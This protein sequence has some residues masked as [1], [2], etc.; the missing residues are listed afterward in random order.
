VDD[1]ATTNED[2]AVVI[3]VV[4]NDTDVDG[5]SP[6]V[7]TFEGQPN[8]SAN[9]GTV[10][11]NGSGELVYT[12]NANFNGVDTITYTI[13]DNNGGTDEGQV[14][15]TVNAVNDDPV[16]VDDTATTNE[17][18]AVVID[19]I[20]NDTDADGNALQVD[21]LEG[22][23]V[24]SALNG[25]IAEDETGRLIYT[26][27]ANFNGNDTITYTI[28]DNNGGTDTGQVA[29]TVI[30]INDA[31]DVARNSTDAI[32]GE[33]DTPIGVSDVV[34]TDVDVG[35]A[36]MFIILT[37]TNGSATINTVAGGLSTATTNASGSVTVS[38]TL[39]Q[40]QTTLAD[41][42]GIT[43]VGDN[44]FIGQANLRIVVTDNG[45][46]GIGSFQD[47]LDIPI[48]IESSNSAPV[49]DLDFN[50]S[51]GATGA[52][53]QATFT[54][55]NGAVNIG[56]L[57]QSDITISDANDTNIESATITLTN[58]P[59]GVDEFLV[60]DVGAIVASSI[61]ISAYNSTSGVITLTGTATKAEYEQALENV[62][63]NNTSSNPTATD[64]IINV[65]I[66][67]GDADSNI[68]VS[69]ISVVGVNDAPFVSTDENIRPTFTEGGAAVVLNNTIM[70]SDVDGNPN[71][72]NPIVNANVL[73][74]QNYVEGEDILEF[75]DTALIES[76][77]Q[78]STGILIL[79]AKVGQTVSEA[80]FEAALQSVTYRNTSENPDG[81]IRE[82]QFRVSDDGFTSNSAVSE[83]AVTPVNDPPAIT[84]P[85]ANPNLV[86]NGG[87][88]N[89]PDGVG[90]VTQIGA[91]DSSTL[92]NWTVVSGAIDLVTEFSVIGAPEGDHV[93]DLN[94]NS[95]LGS[96]TQ[97]ISTVIGETYV[98][99]FQMSGDPLD[100]DTQKDVRVL[101]DGISTEFSHTQSGVRDP[102]TTTTHELFF[103]ATS[104]NTSLIFQSIDTD[105]LNSGAYI[106]DVQVRQANF[107]V[108][109]G[110]VLALTG[111]SVAD[112]DAST[113]LVTISASNGIFQAGSNADVSGFTDVTGHGTSTL[114]F[115]GSVADI[116][117]L[118]NGNLEFI[119][120]SGFDGVDSITLN[121]QDLGQS[122]QGV[123]QSD[124][125]TFN[126]A[127]S[128]GRTPVTV[129]TNGD[130]Y[131]E[132]GPTPIDNLIAGTEGNDTINY[133]FSG[134]GF[135]VLDYSANSVEITVDIDGDA[136]TANVN[137]GPGEDDTIEN[138]NVPLNFGFFGSHGG[139]RIMGSSD[140]DTFNLDT[141][142]ESWLA[143][144]G[145]DGVDSYNI[146][147]ANT[148]LIRLEFVNGSN[149]NVDL[150]LNSGQIIDDG[151][152][153]T[154][155]IIGAGAGSIWEIRGSFTTDTFMGSVG[156]DSFI[157]SFGDD[158]VDGGD[159]FDRVRY[160]REEFQSGVTVDLNNTVGTV[161][162][163][164]DEEFYSQNLSDI[165]HIRGTTFAD[166]ITG[167]AG[168]ERL[169]GREGNDTII[170]G[171]GFDTLE[172][173]DG[174]DIIGVPDFSFELVDGGAGDDQLEIIGGGQDLD[175]DLLSTAEIKNIESINL[176]DAD[177]STEL[178]LNEQ[179]VRDISEDVAQF[180]I[181]ESLG[182]E[183]VLL[184]RGDANDTLNLNDSGGQ[185]GS[186]LLRE[187]ASGDNA[188]DVYDYD[189]SGTVVATVVVDDDVSVN[190]G[191]PA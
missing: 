68:A 46:T 177:G 173:R 28:T 44:G 79:T 81:L 127:V 122:G 167:T 137:K 1:T 98:L 108:Q 176:G 145:Q 2:T 92:P 36:S 7:D 13:T 89:G 111:I 170:G 21:N 130:D 71:G 116:N 42:N 119:P 59:D 179:H 109:S 154:E 162:F 76:N 124:T 32:T 22:Q 29:V 115:R 147:N 103:T 18:T 14:T 149:V 51:S 74:T 25:T 63:Y 187:P 141:F 188:Y 100:G 86:A 144:R 157:T 91:G 40:I 35:N 184:V 55:G 128:E 95:I 84:L 134:D 78:S 73:I 8:A 169:D 189:V 107:S 156:N 146:I 168:D 131:F 27:N 87:F 139:L 82:I 60:V 97:T 190:A 140:G 166:S 106:D 164:A 120:N 80:D 180:I 181:D 153:N 9:N 72:G 129:G 30:A 185:A 17:D 34:V 26:P 45:N 67:D 152:G 101:V 174:D 88:E 4:A 47:S 20:A 161:T 85:A 112:P 94:G 77:F 143:I 83:V 138:I 158:T 175:F 12:P 125:Q 23:P 11:L 132:P 123:A 64:R 3:D 102:L 118:L 96:L 19:V 65:V 38:G 57:A 66:N 121:I 151:F 15:V 159:G 31:P 58:R 24:A 50:D 16:A 135:Q 37:A 178:S 56:D 136:N 69:T 90:G 61:V 93:V 186:W 70:I 172:G 6:Q 133:L 126:V 183:D 33:Q 10:T 113:L 160:D 53:Y 75:T 171:G 49:L 142:T 62:R 41:P 99:T 182:I 39:A 148:G 105:N 114:Q 110:S 165:E 52:N 150:S 163:E 54:E 155:S 43:F 117:A 5:D 104:T 48:T 191:P